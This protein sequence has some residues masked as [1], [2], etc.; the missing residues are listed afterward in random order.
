MILQPLY[1]GLIGCFLWY[2][3][4][5]SI[6]FNNQVDCVHQIT[7][8]IGID[9]M[10]DFPWAQQCRHAHFHHYLQESLPCIL[11]DLAITPSQFCLLLFAQIS[12]YMGT[13]ENV[14]CGSI[15]GIETQRNM[16]RHKLYINSSGQWKENQ[17]LMQNAQLETD[18]W[19]CKRQSVVFC[20]RDRIR[21][22]WIGSRPNGCSCSW[23]WWCW[24]SG[25][26]TSCLMVV[27]RREHGGGDP[28]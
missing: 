22:V 25:F 2:E 11:M 7:G 9:F 21:V 16:Q 26:S 28:W 8:Y 23:T 1:T 18:P 12:W 10:F 5:P 4:K 24:T 15:T 27:V 17:T 3:D 13:N 19:E 14:T 6:S 20:Y